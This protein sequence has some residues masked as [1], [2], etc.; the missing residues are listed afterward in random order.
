[1]H[2]VF[3]RRRD[4]R[5]RSTGFSLVELAVVMAMMAILTALLLPALSGAKEK[6]LRA[7]CKNNQRQLYVVC[8]TYANDNGDV[9]PSAAD[10]SGN[11]HSILL[12]DQTFTNLETAY[13]GGCSNIFYC[14]NLAFD[15]A[16]SPIAVAKNNYGIVIG[17]SYL[18]S[19]VQTSSKI[20]DYGLSP[21]R[22]S[23]AP[24]TN[25][26]LADANYWTTGQSAYSPMIKLAPHTAA[27]AALAQSSTSFAP[28]ATNSI[29]IGAVG[30]NVQYFDGSVV[31]RAIASMQSHP[32][33][34]IN[35]AYG[36]W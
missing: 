21:V 36:N 7:V 8:S 26:L 18:A 1:M 28:G 29:S 3:Y 30:G 17:Y 33:S 4:K 23:I 16:S 9:L 31:W 27:G 19:D 12:S 20:V 11:Y 35:D 10:N 15:G 5:A 25:E 34:S 14:P 6:S 2:L 32:A 24:T 22:F 13:A